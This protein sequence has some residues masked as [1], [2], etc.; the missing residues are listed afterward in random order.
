MGPEEEDKLTQRDDPKKG[1]L[2]KRAKRKVKKATGLKDKGR[3]TERRPSTNPVSLA[4]SEAF[5]ATKKT[6]KLSVR[7]IFTSIERIKLHSQPNLLV[8]RRYVKFL[9]TI[10]CASPQEKTVNQ[11]LLLLLQGGDKKKASSKETRFVGLNRDV[12]NPVQHV[13][14]G[15]KTAKYNVVTF[16]PIFLF[17][18]FSRAAY[19]YF[20]LQASLP[21]PLALCHPIAWWSHAPIWVEARK[22]TENNDC[23]G[24]EHCRHALPGGVPFPHLEGPEARQRLRLCLLWQA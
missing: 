2:Y 20:L 19:L 16:V 7:F 14:N 12:D 17:E 5:Y 3:S 18:I 11:Q 6:L 1:S 22:D 8:K 9:A 15:I 10:S 4:A 24:L 23:E 13:H 21:L